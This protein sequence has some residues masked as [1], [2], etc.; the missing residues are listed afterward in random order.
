MRLG[1]VGAGRVGASFV[2]A[3]RKETDIHV[4]GLVASTWERTEAAGKRYGVTPYRAAAALAADCDVLLLTVPD[5][6]IGPVSQSIAGELTGKGTAGVVFHCSGAMD[7]LPLTPWKT[8]G[9]HVGSLHP[10][11]S[12]AAPGGDQLRHIYMAVDGDDMAQETAKK[13]VTTLES[14]AFTVPAGERPSYH[15]AA[16]FASNFVVTAAALGQMLLSRW[17]ATPADAAKA[18]LPLLMGTMDNL[19]HATDFGKALTGPIARGDIGTVTKHVANLPQAYD[20][21]Y[22]DFAL[23]TAD[24][25]LQNHFLTQ[26]QYDQFRSI[27]AIGKGDSH[28]PESQHS[29][30]R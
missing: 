15:A 22:R 20:R 18:L 12:F 5:D 30:N 2:W 14:T 3:L 10:L 28:E 11:Q 4:V 8:L 27:L 24:I 29:Y 13:I 25:A 21:A 6:A 19:R 9:W 7:L 16:C 26:R 23:Q 17:T 1:I